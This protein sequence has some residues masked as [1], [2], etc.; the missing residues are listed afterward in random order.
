MRCRLDEI[1]GEPE[2]Q[3]RHHEQFEAIPGDEQV[4]LQ[5]RETC[6]QDQEKGERKAGE[7]DA[8][9]LGSC[10][11]MID[12]II[13][14]A[15][16]RFDNMQAAPLTAAGPDVQAPSMTR[17]LILALAATAAL[18]GCNNESHTIDPNK[19]DEPTNAVANATPVELPA[20]IASTKT[21][22][23]KDNSIVQIDWLSDDKS[24]NV[25]TG[26]QVAST[27]LKAPAAGEPM[28]A[29]GYS[30]TGTAEASSV[31]LTRPGTGAET[32]KA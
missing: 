15:M 27:Q 19:T 9:A 25:R 28:V 1:G 10:A 31:T 4:L 20:S 12:H 22:R 29:E 7:A 14:E 32:C 2:P 11:G 5:R 13:D 26:D 3:I 16:A 21:Y 23:C 17:T 18:A 8:N 6:K 24:A 30:L